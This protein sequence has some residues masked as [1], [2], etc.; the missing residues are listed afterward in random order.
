MEAFAGGCS[1][2][3]NTVPT[4]TGFSLNAIKLSKIVFR[5]K[6]FGGVDGN[7]NVELENAGG[8]ELNV[9]VARYSG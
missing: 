9:A 2:E 3:F 1:S 7:S 6:S 4:P 5:N 8:G